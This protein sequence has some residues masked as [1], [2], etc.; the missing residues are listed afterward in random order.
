MPS[1]LAFTVPHSPLRPKK[2]PVCPG[3]PSRMHFFCTVFECPFICTTA[4]EWHA[5][6]LS[7]KR[8]SNCNCNVF[9]EY[10]CPAHP[11]LSFIPRS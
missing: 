5:H 9:G 11:E 3:A 7:H 1:A 4:A 6:K 10:F 2:E 8:P